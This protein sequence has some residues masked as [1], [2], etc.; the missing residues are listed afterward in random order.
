MV[1]IIDCEE[2]DEID[3]RISDLLEDG[4]LRLDD[5][6]TG[7]GYLTAAIRAGSISL[8]ANRFVGTIPVTSSVSVRVT[9]RASIA[10][11]SYMLVKSGIAPTAI[12]GF[13]R[14]YMP[15]FV[16]ADAVEKVYGRSLVDGARLVARRGFAKEYLRPPRQ[17]PWRG[18]LLASETVRR[19]AA[20]GVTYRHE[21]DQSVLSPA[22]IENIALKEAL[23]A[24][25]DW[26]KR[27]D[28][29]NE[30]IGEA[31]R[32]LHDLSAVEKWTGRRS[33]L[34]GQL[35]RRLRS[36]P[37]RLAHYRDPLWAAFLILQ[38]VL[39]EVSHDGY[40]QLDLLIVDVSKV[41]EAFVRRELSIRLSAR[42][43]SVEDGWRSPSPLF[44]DAA[45]FKVHPDVVIR[46][47]GEVVA[48]VDAK[49]KLNP[50]EQDRYEVISFMDALGVT[51]GGF[52]CPTIEGDETRYLGV[53]A[54]GKRLYSFR[55]DLAADDPDTEADRFAANVLAMIEGPEVF[56]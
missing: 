7:K 46:R 36:I 21:F 50:K 28:K 38:S 33:D 14:G 12:V 43:Y 27:H 52:V 35:S 5:R 22:T 9:P 4:E 31:S 49:Y 24:V 17:A 47:N 11:L 10:N 41:F 44:Q 20:K 40:V 54:T 51:V 19:H 48:L 53:T 2:F 29:K 1:E 26:H 56:A 3:L 34:V 42:G 23:I 13:S 32:L 15:R 6:I 8:K 30:L 39:P 55:Y 16:T 18:R 45:A 25:K 37:V